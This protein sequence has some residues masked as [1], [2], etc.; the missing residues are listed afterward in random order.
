MIRIALLLAACL[1]VGCSH[2][3]LFDQT[4]TFSDRNWKVSEPVDLV[5]NVQ[6]VN[7]QYEIGCT[8]RNSVDYPYAR[9]F[10]QYTLLDSTGLELSKKMVNAFLFDQKSG[11]PNGQGGLG[12]V[13]D[14]RVELIPSFQFT[15]PGKYRVKLEHMMREDTL[16]GVLA[17]GLQVK[18]IEPKAP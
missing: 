14:H 3:Q 7:P 12:D 10:V 16:K 5:F 4:V 2:D 13:Y 1:V 17:V 6:N 11:K 9:I 18:E 15:Y 8:I